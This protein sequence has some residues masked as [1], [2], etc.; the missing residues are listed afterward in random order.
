MVAAAPAAPSILSRLEDSA[1]LRFALRRARRLVVSLWVLVTA[2]FF[3]IHLIPGD[4]VR[5]SLG[6]LAPQSLV[7]ARRHALGLDD[8]L[9]SQYV[10]YLR[11]LFTG[12]WGTS[13][14]GDLPVSQIISD[15]LP[16][17][18]EIA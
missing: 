11:N 5:A 16:A 13:M 17:T 10:H 9:W 3:M 14:S 2:S 4:P 1:W 15:R 6:A 8:P 7:L 18:L 12:H